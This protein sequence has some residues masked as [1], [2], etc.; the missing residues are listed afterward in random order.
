MKHRKG[1]ARGTLQHRIIMR[2]QTSVSHRA[3]PGFRLFIAID[4]PEGWTA[5]LAQTQALLRRRGLEQLRWVRPE[6]VHLT[7]KFLGSVDAA[8]VDDLIA[9]LRL[10]AAE[11][12]PF[13]LKLGSLGGFGPPSRPRVVWAGVNGD[14]Y[15]L[16]RLWRAV[17][18]HVGPLGFPPERE[19]FSPHL[20]LARVPDHSPRDLAA[21]IAATLTANEPPLA[22][23][24]LVREIALM[25]SHL[26]PGGARYERLAAAAL[27]GK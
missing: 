2:E 6:G 3:E 5:A 18:A 19:R 23:P 22:G 20:T 9:A 26:G 27:T 7:L 12:S 10:A 21:S 17:E 25:R 11:C 24:L 8:L 14:L 1:I 4:L 15:A 16:T 13:T